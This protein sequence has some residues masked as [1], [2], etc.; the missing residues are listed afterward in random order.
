MV[1]AGR[2]PLLMLLCVV[3]ALR[4]TGIAWGG[5][6]VVCPRIGMLR[7]SVALRF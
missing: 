6:E 7:S 2:R 5:C 1:D 3:L 4:C